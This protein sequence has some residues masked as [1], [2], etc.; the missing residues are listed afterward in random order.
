[1]LRTTGYECPLRH[2]SR[3][4]TGRNSELQRGQRNNSRG[5]P[6]TARDVSA[7]AFVTVVSAPRDTG[8]ES[9]T[10]ESTEAVAPGRHP[11]LVAVARVVVG[12][13]LFGAVVYAAARDWNTVRDTIS[14]MSAVDLALS[15]LLVLAGLG[16]S[17]FVWR[18]SLQE[19]GSLVLI[20]H[21]AKIYLVGQLGKYLP[22]SFWAFL[23]QM[24][25]ASRVGVARVRALAASFVAAGVSVLTGFVIGLLI[26]PSVGD[27]EAW[28]YVLFGLLAVLC[29]VALTPPVLTRLVDFGLRLVRRPQLD[30]PVTWAGMLRAAGWAFASWLAYGLSVWVLVMGAGAPAGESFLPSVAGA[31]LAMTAGFLVFIAPS[32]IGV[33]EAVLVAALSPVLDSGEALSVALV[34]RLAFTL[35]DLIGAAAALP[36]R[37]RVRPETMA[38]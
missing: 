14:R 21:A 10:A 3:S 23:V 31:A 27:A 17:V 30:D 22:G 37:L 9:E 8:L 2:S 12:L 7:L 13:V 35:A 5:I 36:I 4:S 29:A 20:H 16:A 11:R 34:V 32:G 38:A 33:R 19:L 24:Q 28:R 26:I 25:L 15:E 6:L 1:M 18:A